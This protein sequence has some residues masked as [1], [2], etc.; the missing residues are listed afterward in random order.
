MLLLI[1]KTTIENETK[2]EANHTT[3]NAED[4]LINIEDNLVK[5]QM[6]DEE[7][8]KHDVMNE[9]KKPLGSKD[10]AKEDTDMY[11][12]EFERVLFSFFF[13]TVPRKKFLET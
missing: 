13:V 1:K 10:E 8:V 6:S 7:S 3:N 4:I 9:E 11:K 5:P 12:D 2:N